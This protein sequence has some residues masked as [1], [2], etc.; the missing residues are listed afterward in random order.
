VSSECLSELM[1][2]TGHH[3]PTVDASFTRNRFASALHQ[4]EHASAKADIRRVFNE[5]VLRDA[6]ATGQRLR[7][8]TRRG[9]SRRNAASARGGDHR[10]AR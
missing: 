6:G 5:A 3:A 8:P 7:S 4:D 9:S 2:R 10:E 1:P